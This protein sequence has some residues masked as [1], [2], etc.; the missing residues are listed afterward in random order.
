M[1]FVGQVLR[2][3]L[4]VPQL[5]RNIAF[6]TRPPF[7][8]SSQP[9]V[10]FLGTLHPALERKNSDMKLKFHA[11]CQYAANLPIEYSMVPT[12]S[13]VEIQEH[14]TRLVFQ[15]AC[16]QTWGG[17]PRHQTGMFNIIKP[18]IHQTGS[19]TIFPADLEPGSNAGLYLVGVEVS[20]Y[21]G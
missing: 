13:A 21:W 3:G 15:P 20:T 17:G 8:G 2:L 19:E 10:G 6:F 7:L 1:T 4:I 14:V 16:R 18:A 12:C 9:L 11:L 5:L